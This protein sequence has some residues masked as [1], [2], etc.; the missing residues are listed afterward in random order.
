MF[1][2]ASNIIQLSFWS[3][4]IFSTILTLFTLIKNKHLSEPCF[5]CYQGIAVYEL[6]TV[7]F[8]GIYYFYGLDSGYASK[9][10]GVLMRDLV[11]QTVWDSLVH[12]PIV[13]TI[14]LSLQ[15]ASA[16]L[17]PQKFS[18]FNSPKINFRV[19]VGTFLI[20]ALGAIPRPFVF[21]SNGTI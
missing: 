17:F 2:K 11:A 6:F 5:I 1:W 14:F 7:V 21:L 16:C 8:N 9:Y 13:L 18:H 3:L 4:G 12:P 20:L 15:R 19:T 10:I